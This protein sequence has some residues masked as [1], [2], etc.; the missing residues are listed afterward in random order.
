MKHLY[1]IRHAKSSW[2]D[3]SLSDFDRPLNKRGKKDAP[4]MGK[5]LREQNIQ[6][7]IMISSPALRAKTTALSIAQ[8]IRYQSEI[9]FDQNIYESSVETLDTILKS[10]SQQKRK[11]KYLKKHKMV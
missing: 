3:F 1:I 11:M 2:K 6:A 9:V 10:I 4:F 5:I 7:D 8:E